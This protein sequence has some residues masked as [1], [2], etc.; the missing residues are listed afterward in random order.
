[1]VVTKKEKLEK[2]QDDEFFLSSVPILF[3]E[4]VSY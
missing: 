1:M 4:R 2:R 3:D